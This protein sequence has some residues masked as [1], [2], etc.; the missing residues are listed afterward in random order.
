MECLA[1][2]LRM[3]YPSD[4][5][6]ILVV[7]NG[8]TDRTAEIVKAFSVR[9]LY[10]DRRGASHARNRGIEA[11]KGEIMAFTDADCAV[12]T[13]WLREL[14]QGFDGEEVGGVEGDVV[15]YPSLT[16]IEQYHARIGSHSR[17]MRL[18][19]PL[20]PMVPGANVAFLRE[21]FDEIGLFDSQLAAC[22]DI[23]L[24]WRLTEETRFELRYNPKAVVFHRHYSTIRGFFLKYM[25]YGRG[26][27]NL[28]AKYPARLPWGW[29]KEIRAW[30]SVAEFGWKATRSVVRYGLR[31]GTKKDVYDAY[32]TFLRKIGVRLGF[33]R[34]SLARGR[35]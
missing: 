3:D 16:P 8:S 29:R 30:G 17:Q 13:G 32:L 34:E 10:E 2:L 33:L 25:K 22:E 1:S 14:V 4:R 7:D 18:A 28:R 20:S 19:S 35:R 15:A 24:T 26:Y 12:T 27:A 6:E 5:R 21:V 11:S 31:V 9:Y 23:D